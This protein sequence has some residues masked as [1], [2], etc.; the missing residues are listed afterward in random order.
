MDVH[1]PQTGD[2]KTLEF[3]VAA[4]TVVSEALGLQASGPSASRGRLPQT[5][6]RH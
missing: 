6:D 5:P 4:G 2:P 1:E 3:K